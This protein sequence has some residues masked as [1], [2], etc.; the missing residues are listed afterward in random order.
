MRAIGVHTYAGGFLQGLVNSGV[1]AR[2]S[3]ESWAPGANLSTAL[4][5]SRVL[6]SESS[7]LYSTHPDIV[8]GN[9]PCSRF[10]C[11]SCHRYSREQK[12]DVRMFPELL[13]IF[14]E[15]LRMKPRILWWETGPLGFTQGQK[16][17]ATADA[18]VRS[19]MGNCRTLVIKVDARDVGVPQWRPRTHIMHFMDDFR[20]DGLPLGMNYAGTV[21]NFIDEHRNPGPIVPY[22]Y[23]DISMGDPV[24]DSMVEQAR[25]GF[26]AAKPKIVDENAAYAPAV[27]GSRQFCW[28]NENRWWSLNEYAALQGFPK[29]IDYAR[30]EKD[31]GYI[32]TV[33]SKGLSPMVSQWVYQKIVYPILARGYVAGPTPISNVDGV[34]YGRVRTQ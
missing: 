25:R 2:L 22:S 23:H 1:D 8:V 4:G 3:V 9:P 12:D 30:V 33:L 26:N 10:S 19:I 5:F 31:P 24:G 27:L 28:K 20:R 21:R 11:M 16:L 32:I 15:G 14:G 17:I 18:H 29:G 7:E 6:F 34:L 13:E